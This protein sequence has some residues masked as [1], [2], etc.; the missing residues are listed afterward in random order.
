MI[1]ALFRL[2]YQARLS[3]CPFC[4]IVFVN[5]NCLHNI[6]RMRSYAI[7]EEDTVFFMAHDEKRFFFSDEN[8]VHGKSKEKMRLTLREGAIS[9]CSRFQLFPSSLPKLLFPQNIPQQIGTY[10][11]FALMHTSL[12]LILSRRVA[13]SLTPVIVRRVLDY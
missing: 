9:I 6:N 1:T 2:T 12:S 13:Y 3:K 5:E 7:S 11:I 10:I 8:R 4:P